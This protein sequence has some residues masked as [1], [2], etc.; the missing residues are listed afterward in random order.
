VAVTA[1]SPVL[2]GA[3]YFTLI[4]LVLTPF[5]FTRGRADLAAL[6][7][8]GRPASV[9]APGLL[10]GVMM[11]AHVIALRL[12]PVAYMIAVKRTSLLMGVVYGRFLFGEGNFRERLA[13]AAL[14][15]AGV[16]LIG[17]FP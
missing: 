13:G 2:F 16:L 15:L 11:A 9:L 17:L 3:V 10:Y 6:W 14:M 5:A 1:A 12:A 8:E 4:G 7:R